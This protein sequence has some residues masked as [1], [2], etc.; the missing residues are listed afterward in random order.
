M[1][2][3]N[4][5]QDQKDAVWLI[6]GLLTFAAVVFAGAGLLF[7]ISPIISILLFM[8]GCAVVTVACVGYYVEFVENNHK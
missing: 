4:F 6:L 8:G 1:N 2:F 3:E 7:A 5:T